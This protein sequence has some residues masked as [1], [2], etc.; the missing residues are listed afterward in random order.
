MK[1]KEI[2]EHCG[3]EDKALLFVS[4]LRDVDRCITGI[5]PGEVMLVSG[6]VSVG[7]TAFCVFWALDALKKGTK[8][9]YIT[10]DNPVRVAERFAKVIDQEQV[11]NIPLFVESFQG[12]GTE[13]DDDA[14]PSDMERLFQHIAYE[15]SEEGKKDM[16]PVEKYGGEAEPWLVIIDGADPVY[17]YYPKARGQWTIRCELLRRYVKKVKELAKKHNAAVMMTTSAP[18][19]EDTT[20]FSRETASCIPLAEC[21][22]LIGRTPDIDSMKAMEVSIEKSIRG[23]AAVVTVRLNR[24]LSRFEDIEKSD[25][26]ESGA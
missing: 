18:L 12:A 13:E 17:K 23:V 11:R 22:C 8:V 9:L 16:D 4:G 14:V 20:E 24:E 26:S 19:P 15:E 21:A 1:I 5:A 2:F 7:K 6:E 10:P 3:K 25:V